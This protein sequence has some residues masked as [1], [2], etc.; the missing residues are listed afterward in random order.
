MPHGWFMLW[1]L[2]LKRRSPGDMADVALDCLKEILALPDGRCQGAALHGL[3]HLRHPD[4]PAVV[5]RWI[6]LY[7]KGWNREWLEAFRDGSAL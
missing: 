5:Q 2:I 4:R 3:N 6:D 7:G 1:H